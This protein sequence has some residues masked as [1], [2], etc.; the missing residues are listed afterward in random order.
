M[1]SEG[2][3][4]HLMSHD[5]NKIV[6]PPPN[7]SIVLVPSGT[8]VS[9]SVEIA[10]INTAILAI[11]TITPIPPNTAAMIDRMNPAVRIPEIH[12]FFFAFFAVTSPAIP[13]IK[14]GTHSH[15]PTKNPNS[16]NTEPTIPRT[17]LAIATP[18]PLS[19]FPL[20]ICGCCF[21]FAPCLNTFPHT[22]H[23]S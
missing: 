18:F 14:P 20:C 19:L 4:I 12:P 11:K 5:C 21:S 22:G 16:D 17:K 8:G 3:L 1:L 2:V 10:A 6:A 23:T 7:W 15:N 13:Q 9:S